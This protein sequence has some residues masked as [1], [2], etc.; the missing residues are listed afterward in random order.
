MHRKMSVFSRRNKFISTLWAGSR[1]IM[2]VDITTINCHWCACLEDELE[3]LGY[4]DESCL[5]RCSS[6][7]GDKPLIKHGLERFTMEMNRPCQ[8]DGRWWSF[9]VSRR[10]SLVRYLESDQL[11]AS[12]GRGDDESRSF[13]DTRRGDDGPRGPLLWRWAPQSYWADWR[14]C[15][16][17]DESSWADPA[18]WTF[19]LVDK[20]RSNGL[21]LMYILIERL[22]YCW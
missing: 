5:F 4:S 12:R 11:R 13:A 8:V 19:F 6:C 16:T 7:N 18:I 10:W 17:E 3:V 2:H 21:Y 22:I 14:M 1:C 9:A 20:W 15:G